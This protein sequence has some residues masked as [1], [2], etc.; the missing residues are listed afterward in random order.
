MADQSYTLECP[1]S[2]KKEFANVV[3]RKFRRTEQS[4][5]LAEARREF[6]QKFGTSK[7]DRHKLTMM[8]LIFFNPT[9][10][11]MRSVSVINCLRECVIFFNISSQKRKEKDPEDDTKENLSD[12]P[13]QPEETVITDEENDGLPA[14][15]IKIGPDGE[16]T[17]DEKSL[18]IE[19]KQV[20]RSQQQIQN[21][22]LVDGDNNTSYGIY[23]KVKRTKL[24]SKKET[25]RFYRALNTIGTDFSLMLP[26]FP[27]RT[28]RDLT[29]KF[30]K[31][32]KMNRTLIDRALMVPNT[33]DISEIQREVEI[34]ER[35]EREKEKAK[36]EVEQLAKQ[37]AEE[38]R[39][40]R[41]EPKTG[42]SV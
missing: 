9:S 25:L 23:K 7:P 17:I 40:K 15:Q 3:Q 29:M 16:I 6:V 18:V 33:Y 5:K 10:N 22:K 8:D 28:R 27:G 41:G 21:S 19:N 36:Q 26:L 13:D 37:Q 1:H 42:E 14:P 32:E 35:E 34:E 30:K 4:R 38:K 39:K 12:E 31:E 20:K 2:P 24:W 11:P